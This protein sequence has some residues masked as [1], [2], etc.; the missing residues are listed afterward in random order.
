MAPQETFA[1]LSMN[2]VTEI[3]REAKATAGC[4]VDP[5]AGMPVLASNFTLPPD[6]LE[7]YSLCGGLDMFPN[8]DWGWRIV[9]PSEFLRADKVILELVYRDH[10]EDFDG[11]LSEGLY[12][13]AVRGCGPDYISIDTHP[14]RLGRCFDSYS[15][16]HA[17]E[18]S[19]VVAL[20]FTEMLNKLFENR[21]DI[22]F[23]ED[24]FYGYF[25]QPDNKLKLQGR[26]SPKVR[27]P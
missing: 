24:A 18:S 8:E 3:I 25:G 27:L 6:A 22:V 9:K 10:P 26:Q 21:Q 11:T 2:T 5:P 15:G 13:V 1:H 7:F 4:I 23:W 20:S 17:T 16:D 14:A 19:R 12:V